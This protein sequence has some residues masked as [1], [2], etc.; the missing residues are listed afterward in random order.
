MMMIYLLYINSLKIKNSIVRYF[1][2]KICFNIVFK[3]KINKEKLISYLNT[4]EIFDYNIFYNFMLYKSNEKSYLIL[5]EGDEISEEIKNKYILIII[6]KNDASTY[7]S[8]QIMVDHG[9]FDGHLLIN[10]FNNFNKNNYL[11]KKK[12]VIESF[13]YS[14]LHVT[15][16]NKYNYEKKLF[17]ISKSKILNIQN[18]FKTYNNISKL[19]IVFSIICKRFMKLLNKS[20]LNCLIVK[21][22][23]NT[24]FFDHSFINGNMIDPHILEIKD[25][26]LFEMSNCIRKS[27]SNNNINLKFVDIQ[28]ISWCFSNENIVSIK[29]NHNYNKTITSNIIN[30]F[31]SFDHDNYLIMT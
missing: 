8:V 3:N 5:D 23:R 4:F 12:Y 22:S 6:F 18:K 2:T 25:D 7:Q 14:N 21:S 13:N 28:F 10:M 26:N 31:V 17:T 9:L 30:I 16:I 20:Y 27:Y 19:D 29:T 1:V 15:S 24:Q 11:F